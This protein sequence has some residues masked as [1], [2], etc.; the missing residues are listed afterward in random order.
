MLKEKITNPWLRFQIMDIL[1]I[2]EEEK[3]EI[4]KKAFLFIVKCTGDL[5]IPY[6]EIK[7]YLARITK[8]YPVIE[9]IKDEEILESLRCFIT[10]T[11]G[12]YHKI[13]HLEMLTTIKIF[14]KNL[15]TIKKIERMIYRSYVLA[16][17]YEPSHAFHIQY[18]WALSKK[19]KNAIVRD[20]IKERTGYQ[21]AI[22]LA[23]RF[24][25][26]TK[27]LYWA[28]SEEEKMEITEKI[29]KGYPDNWKKKLEKIF[30][31]KRATSAIRK[32]YERLLIK[33]N[34][35]EAEVVGK[36]PT[37]ILKVLLSKINK[38]YLWDASEFAQRFMPERKEILKE[39]KI[40]EDAEMAFYATL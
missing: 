23:K 12:T 38:C 21:S 27:K 10:K 8:K 3:M 13:T 17:P 32:Y 20:V 36:Y 19:E 31:N 34:Y 22:F 39:L 16:P 4:T 30:G 25:M 33:N 28:L 5:Y 9:K 29:I 14:F 35:D 11:P 6:D 15:E 1:N 24:K 2:S 40:L 18:K 7:K 37:I 26:P